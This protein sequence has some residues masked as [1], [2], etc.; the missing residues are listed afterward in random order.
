MKHN[1][2]FQIKSFNHTEGDEKGTFIGLAN[3]RWFRDHVGDVTTSNA[4]TATIAKHKTDGT[5]PKLLLQHEVADVIGV[6]LDMW[7]DDAGLW[8]RGK[9]CL[10]TVKGAETYALMKMG[11]LI[12]LSIGYVVKKEQYDAA[13]N[14]NFLEEIYIREVSIVTFPANSQSNI[15]EVKSEI[16]NNEKTEVIN[17]PI[18]DDNVGTAINETVGKVIP[19]EIKSKL[20]NLVFAIKLSNIKF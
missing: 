20:S 2:N 9:L 4:F 17:K 12:D 6:F 15:T 19:E 16:K 14:T 3:K 10:E 1:L 13:T 8:V 5:M 11:A 7:E 18:I